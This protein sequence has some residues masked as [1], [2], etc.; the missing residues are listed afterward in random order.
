MNPWSQLL[1]TA[2]SA[3]IKKYLY[4]ILKDR[5]SRN[6]EF[7]ERLAS[8]IVTNKDVEGLGKLVADLYEV[9][10]VKS[11]NDHKEILEAKGYK[12][13]IC[14]EMSEEIIDQN[15]IFPKSK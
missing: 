4:D 10:Y 5:Y 3:H 8:S 12:A 6:E 15:R 1:N 2:F 14:A 7:I 9:G 11:V 13:T